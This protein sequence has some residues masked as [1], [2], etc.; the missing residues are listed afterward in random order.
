M[1][2]LHLA[3][4]GRDRLAG[5]GPDRRAHPHR[6]AQRLRH[7]GLVVGE[8]L[9]IVTGPR[10]RHVGE[11]LVELLFTLLGLT[12]SLAVDNI[13]VSQTP[14]PATLTLLAMGALALIRRK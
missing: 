9:G 3:L 7:G 8:D 13:E 6:T 1:C 5:H 4:H 2:L 10:H 12:E 11:A 14:E